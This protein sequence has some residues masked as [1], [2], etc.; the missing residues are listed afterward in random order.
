MTADRPPAAGL[1][2]ATNFP[3][4][5]ANE[6]LATHSLLQEILGTAIGKSDLHIRIQGPVPEDA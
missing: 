4:F 1:T 5:N 6:I 2:T 3:E